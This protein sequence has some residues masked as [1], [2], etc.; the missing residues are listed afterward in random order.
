MKKFGTKKCG[1]CQVVLPSDAF[2]LHKRNH[3]G[4]HYMCKKCRLDYDR[5]WRVENKDKQ[6][7]TKAAW[8]YK[9]SRAEVTRLRET[10]QCEACS[11]PL[12]DTKCIDHCHETGL[13]RGVLCHQCNITL[14]LL[15]DNPHVLDALAVYLRAR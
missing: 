15:K 14:G 11:K 4:L 3:D 5:N 13:V 1:K 2:G 7:V 9:I 6:S 8:R 10:T 12:D